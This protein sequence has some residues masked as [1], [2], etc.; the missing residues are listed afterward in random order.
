MHSR[1][2]KISTSPEKD[3]SFTEF[4]APEW[5]TSEIADYV[6]DSD[7]EQ[8]RDFLDGLFEDNPYMTLTE[9]RTDDGHVYYKWDITDIKQ[10]QQ[11]Y[12]RE[13]FNA[14]KKEANDISLEDFSGSD[15][16]T[17]SLGR[18]ILQRF[19][20]YMADGHEWTPMDSFIRALS[21]YNTQ[22]FYI[23]ASLD[24]HY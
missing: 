5:F 12:F 18:T 4:D 7:L 22:T 1:I 11:A 24:Y 9:E 14:F 19:D 6:T 21:H 8:D 3:P 16:R 13:R 15:F 23:V 20:L 2:F 10:A 17:Y